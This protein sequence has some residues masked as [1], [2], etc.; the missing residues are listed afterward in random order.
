MGPLCVACDG[1]GREQEAQQQIGQE[2]QDR[3]QKAE[4]QIMQEKGVI[5][6]LREVQG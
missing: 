1:S 4:Q 2:E 6:A 5:V 3:E